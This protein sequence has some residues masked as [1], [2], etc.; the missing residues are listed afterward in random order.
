MQ[1]PAPQIEQPSSGRISVQAGDGAICPE[2]VATRLASAKRMRI[3]VF[4]AFVCEKVT[5][6]YD[7]IA[8]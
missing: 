8:L 7:S 5:N 3:I 1:E 4:L 6:M 2:A